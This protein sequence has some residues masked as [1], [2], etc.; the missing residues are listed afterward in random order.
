[1]KRK[2][3]NLE[4]LAK[5]SEE[6]KREGKS[7]VHC[8]GSYDVLHTG[9]IQHFKAAKTRGDILM[10]TLTADRFIDKG[11]NRPECKENLRANTLAELEMV[12]YIAV[13]E[14]P[15]GLPA[16]S[17]IK[18]SVYVKG[19]EFKDGKDITERVRPEFDLVETLG[20]KVYLTEEITFSSSKMVNRANLSN[21]AFAFVDRFSDEISTKEIADSLEDLR[22]MK[23]LVIGDTIIDE[24]HYVSP[25]ERPPKETMIASKFLYGESFAGATLAAANHLAGFLDNVDLITCLG[26]DSSTNYEDFIVKNLKSN[27]SPT[28]FYRDDAPTVIKRRY[29]EEAFLKKLFE[30]CFIEET[31]MP[32]NISRNISE[33]IGDVAKNYDLVMAADFGHGLLEGRVINALESQSKF[34]AV[35]TQTNESNS[36][37]NPITKYLRADYVCIDEPEVRFSTHDRFGDLEKVVTNLASLREY[38][39]FSITR[40]HKGSLMYSKDEGFIEIPVFS[41]FGIKDTIGA[42]DAYFAVTSPYV[43][44][45]NSLKNVGFL[46]NVVGALAVNIIGNKESIDRDMVTKFVNSLLK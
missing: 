28:F 31:D 44:A 11:P 38:Q 14:D 27:I 43:V 41:G 4:E 34:L 26:S 24:Y 21:E 3:F 13:V 18:P 19:S 20:G 37:Y 25:L 10:V 29:I 45:G 9:H 30:I 46:G 8:H 2:I 15:T 36:G 5:I 7:I 22:G 17:A 39:K 32:E 6:F 33:Y 12:D 40:G 35:T 42:G 23:A 16:I 1:M